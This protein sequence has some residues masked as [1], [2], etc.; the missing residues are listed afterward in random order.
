[1][2][3]NWSLLLAITVPIFLVCWSLTI[4]NKNFLDS[5]IKPQEEL[6][7][8]SKLNLQ[9]I[10]KLERECEFCGTNQLVKAVKIS[11]LSGEVI[12]KYLCPRCEEKYRQLSL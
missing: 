11:S 7:I 9:R 2:F 6:N 1:M 3:V 8:F 4:I 10:F 5:K 12:I